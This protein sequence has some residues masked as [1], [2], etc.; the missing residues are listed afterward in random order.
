MSGPPGTPG[1]RA[2]I[3]GGT[4]LDTTCIGATGAL[5]HPADRESLHAHLETYFPGDVDVVL[6]PYVTA[7]RLAIATFFL[8]RGLTVEHDCV[9][10]NRYRPYLDNPSSRLRGEVKP[11]GFDVWC[12]E[13]CLVW[14]TMSRDAGVTCPALWLSRQ[15]RL[16]VHLFSD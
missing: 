7:H 5:D 4:T 12:N 15:V 6:D 3:I 14:L 2:L 11:P 10:D 13:F 1:Q 16:F 8:A 9:V